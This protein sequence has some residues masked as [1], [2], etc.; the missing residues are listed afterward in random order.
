MKFKFEDVEFRV[1][2]QYDVN[3]DLLPVHPSF[4]YA[5]VI[6]FYDKW[7]WPRGE[8]ERLKELG[9]NV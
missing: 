5:D 4:T 2:V 1:A 9:F 3:D 6:A 8:K 7:G